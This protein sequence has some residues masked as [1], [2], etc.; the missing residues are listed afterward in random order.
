MKFVKGNILD[1]QHGIIGHQVNC[2][3]VMGAGLAKQIRQ[4]YPRAYTEYK[5]IMGKA[6]PRARFGKCQIVEVISG[7]LYIAN[8]FGQFEYRPRGIQHTN[9]DALSMALVGLKTWHSKYA[10]PDFPIF[11]PHGL[12]CGLAGGDWKQVLGRIE[13]AIP[14]AIIVRLDKA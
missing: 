3:M 5:E 11:L 4:K 12:G 13:S 6:E 8:L 9:Y 2:Q 1:A 14:N 7:T 10:N